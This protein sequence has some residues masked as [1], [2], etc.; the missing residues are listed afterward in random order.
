[1]AAGI[2]KTTAYRLGSRTGA[3]RI[4]GVTIVSPAGGPHRP[5][6]AAVKNAKMADAG[7]GPPAH[8]L[9]KCASARVTSRQL[10]KPA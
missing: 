3:R 8:P 4:G 10:R 6:G 5:F 9:R 7:G 1:M 2:P